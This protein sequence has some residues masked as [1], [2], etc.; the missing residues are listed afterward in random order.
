[1]KSEN[2][3]NKECGGWTNVRNNLQSKKKK[4]GAGNIKE[5]WREGKKRKKEHARKEN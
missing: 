5:D 2:T 1:M 3:A 4:G